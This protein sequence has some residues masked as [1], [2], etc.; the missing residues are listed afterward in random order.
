MKIID[1]LN[2]ILTKTLDQKEAFQEVSD[3][4]N[5]DE[6]GG[7]L[8]QFAK[9]VKEES[10]RLIKAISDLGGDVETTERQTDHESIAWVSRPLPDSEDSQAL[11]ECLIK[12][13]R[14]KEEDYNKLFASEEID[15][16]LKNHLIKH[17]KETESNLV[18]FQSA[19]KSLEQGN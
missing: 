2:M 8:D 14:R 13:E 5:E 18:F 1:E 16:E 12:A 17:R 10:E 9:V 3:R 4:F 6:I 19:L 11:L 7:K 15:R